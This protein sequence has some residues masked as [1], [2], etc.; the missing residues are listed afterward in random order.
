[1]GQE[2]GVDQIPVTLM[3]VIFTFS[4]LPTE[5][6]DILVARKEKE[7]PEDQYNEIGR[8]A[9]HND[10]AEI[11]VAWED[12]VAY[13]GITHYSV[14]FQVIGGKNGEGIQAG[15]EIAISGTLPNGQRV[16]ITKAL[17]FGTS[18]ILPP[19]PIPAPACIPDGD[20]DQGNP[21]NCCSSNSIA[22]QNFLQEDNICR[23]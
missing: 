6:T 13:F 22:G 11:P 2:P 7:S 9:I 17:Q 3:N 5:V 20:P 15:A 23:Q 1:V 19:A 4:G 10:T 18:P 8:H 12:L 14:W 16:T 21:T